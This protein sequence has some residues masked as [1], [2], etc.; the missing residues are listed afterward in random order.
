ME[1]IAKLYSKTG[2]KFME[3][4]YA[5]YAFKE[6]LNKL[7]KEDQKAWKKEFYRRI[8]KRTY[9]FLMRETKRYYS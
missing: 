9:N 8:G 3:W 7:S 2:Q 6:E 4:N 5:I 1:K